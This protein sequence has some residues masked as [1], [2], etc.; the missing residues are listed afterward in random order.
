MFN[1]LMECLQIT[2]NLCLAFVYILL[3]GCAESVPIFF[4]LNSVTL[5]S[6]IQKILGLCILWITWILVIYSRIYL[7]EHT[8]SQV[9]VG[10]LV[11]SGFGLLWYVL[12]ERVIF[13]L[14]LNGRCF[15]LIIL[16]SQVQLSFSGLSLKLGLTYWSICIGLYTCNKRFR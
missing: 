16:W 12:N 13:D 5:T 11:G 4:I 6:R 3:F 8:L 14:F 15:V 2:A 1:S 7:E 9:V 10:I